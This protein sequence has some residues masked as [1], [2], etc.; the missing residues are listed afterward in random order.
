MYCT[1]KV[2]D[3]ITQSSHGLKVRY[4][5]FTINILGLI[6][7]EKMFHQLGFSDLVNEDE[8]PKA[9]PLG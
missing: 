4:N 8:T 2:R 1:L 5:Y 6:M 9:G 3:S 7:E